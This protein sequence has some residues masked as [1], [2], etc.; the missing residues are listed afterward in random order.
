MTTGHSADQTAT[1]D[2]KV[3]TADRRPAL[4]D[5]RSRGRGQTTLDFAVGMSVFLLTLAFVFTFVPGMLA[6]FDDTTQAETP[7]ANRVAEDLV[8]RSLGDADTPYVLDEQC[9]RE[10]F[11]LSNTNPDG[12]EFAGETTAERV[13]VASWQPVNVTLRGDPDDDG[14]SE[15]LCLDGES[16]VERSA[17][18][19]SNDNVEVL[20]G[21]S[22]PAGSGGKTV[23]A[24]RVALLDGRDV[25]VEV[26]MW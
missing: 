9:T 16:L 13:S 3:P 11:N 5:G 25:T 12:C 23:T 6:P 15:T 8:T 10:F 21:G 4:T 18:T 14:V 24:T 26:V 17:C 22:D 19:P 7:A 1:S 20:S 2:P